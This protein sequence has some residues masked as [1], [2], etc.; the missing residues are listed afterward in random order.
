[1]R[2]TPTDK[3]N[4]TQRDA[5]PHGVGL[6][7]Q[8]NQAA[9]LLATGLRKGAVARAVGVDP[10]T[11]W[12]WEKD[13]AFRRACGQQ[14]HDAL[15]ATRSLVVDGRL[16]ALRLL[17]DVLDDES[18][19]HRDR[20]AAAKALLNA[21]PPPEPA[22]PPVED[23][24]E[25]EPVFA[26]DEARVVAHNILELRRRARRRELGIDDD[27]VEGGHEGTSSLP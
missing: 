11:I 16:R 15:D 22:T 1:M 5:S 23:T 13:S 10:T 12:R 25:R 27:H 8:Q 7:P 6:S 21:C 26:P 24:A 9:T 3:R 18:I 19:E 20:I 14:L 2:T 4:E 17:V